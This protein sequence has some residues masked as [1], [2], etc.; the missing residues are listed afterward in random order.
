MG[1]Y[2]ELVSHLVEILL[3]LIENSI[4]LGYP[5][6]WGTSSLVERPLRMREAQGSIPWFS[7]RRIDLPLTEDS[8]LLG[9]GFIYFSLLVCQ[10]L[11]VKTVKE[12]EETQG[13]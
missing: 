10:L 13:D 6:N 1:A 8:L 12:H 5:G 2:P 9:I 4:R 3:V 7:R 11:I